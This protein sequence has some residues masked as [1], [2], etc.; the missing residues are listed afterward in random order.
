MSQ[1]GPRRLLAAAGQEEGIVMTRSF[2]TMLLMFE[3][4]LSLNSGA[5]TGWADA[6]PSFGAS[7][8]ETYK[9]P[10]ASMINNGDFNHFVFLGSGELYGIAREAAL[11]MEEMA[12]VAAEAYH[13]LEYRHGPKSVAGNKTLVVAFLLPE[14]G[15]Y[16]LS[17]LRDLRTLGTTTIAV[18][19]Q[20]VVAGL[21]RVADLIVAF[22][23]G[24]NAYQSLCLSLPVAQLLGLNQAVKRGLDPDRPRHLTQ[25]VEL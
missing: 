23:R 22:P 10:L 17:L 2:S 7:L 6:L 20:Q 1:K 16:Q 21:S 5:D 14:Q 18:G 8:I 4:F 9:G 11:K 13:T 24:V 3:L 25:V 19:E 12:I 15:E